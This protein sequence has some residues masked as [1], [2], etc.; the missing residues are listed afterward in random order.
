MGADVGPFPVVLTAERDGQASKPSPLALEL[1]FVLVA[2]GIGTHDP[3]SG[4]TS[5]RR[6]VVDDDTAALL[7]PLGN[8]FRTVVVTGVDDVLVSHGSVPAVTVVG[9]PVG[10]VGG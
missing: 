5:C 6:G 7:S 3:R 10:V 4:I 2:G 8:R 9:G 1:S